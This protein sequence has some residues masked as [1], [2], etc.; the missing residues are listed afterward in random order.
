MFINVYKCLY[1]FSLALKFTK[2]GPKKS[3]D[4]AN[5]DLVLFKY[6]LCNSKQQYQW[7]TWKPKRFQISE[8]E[9]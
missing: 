3:E 7:D 5:G 4:G 1:K 6:A 2:W 9:C 8:F